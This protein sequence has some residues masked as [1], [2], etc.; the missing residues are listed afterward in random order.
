MFR[1][2]D[3]LASWRASFSNRSAISNAQFE[4]LETHIMEAFDSGI[5]D[6]MSPSAAFEQA[7][8]NIGR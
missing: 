1:I 3:A 4:E 5:A 7:I 2:E 6:G 8:A